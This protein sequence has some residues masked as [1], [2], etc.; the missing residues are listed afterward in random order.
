MESIK[1]VK[2]DLNHRYELA[3]GL[4]KNSKLLVKLIILVFTVYCSLF[5]VHSF[6]QV[7]INKTGAP[8]DPSA[9]LDVSGTS[10]GTLIPCMTTVQR[11]LI[12]GSDGIAGHAPAPGLLIFNISS[13][14]FEAYV[15]GTWNTVSCPSPCAP[16]PIPSLLGPSDESCTSFTA[17]WEAVSTGPV[18]YYIDV[19]T[20]DFTTQNPAFV[21]GYHNLNIGNVTSFDV[22]GLQNSLTYYYRVRAGTACQS[23]NPNPP[24]QAFT[25]F[26]YSTPVPTDNGSTSSCNGI[27]FNWSTIPGAV[28]YDFVPVGQDIP[29][30]YYSPNTYTV[31][32]PTTT[33]G[34]LTGLLPYIGYSIGVSAKDACGNYTNF[35]TIGPITP[36]C[37]P[38]VQFYSQT[39]CGSGGTGGEY[40]TF[41]WSD[42][43]GADHYSY[44]YSDNYG[45][46]PMQGP[47]YE[48]QGPPFYGYDPNCVPYGNTIYF[49]VFVFNSSNIQIGSGST[50]YYVQP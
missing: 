9:M 1:V 15:N 26:N 31:A 12:I 39:S 2:S 19:S 20:D 47:V 16:P 40:V 32:A 21:N 41:S 37:N 50:Y 13:N 44:S 46:S 4:Q 17:H 5:A 7:G 18:S 14:C 48:Y 25:G 24:E 42:V 28:E 11:D 49:W 3:G 6:S 38:T 33:T 23:G 29:G 36:A 22:T 27:T 8:A 35:G 10:Q 34:D 30:Y 43:S 45:S